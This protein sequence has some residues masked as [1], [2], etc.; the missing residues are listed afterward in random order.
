MRIEDAIPGSYVRV[1]LTGESGL[2]LWTLNSALVYVVFAAQHNPY[3][4]CSF[5]EP[6]DLQLLAQPV[7]RRK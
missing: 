2:V 7:E 3:L 1:R 4:T 6:D 5:H